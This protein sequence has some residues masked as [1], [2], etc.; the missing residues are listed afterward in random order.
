MRYAIF[1]WC[2]I[3]P[4][5]FTALIGQNLILNGGFEEHSPVKCLS[6]DIHFG[7]F[8]GLVYHW[9]NMDYGCFLCDKNYKRT[10][11]EI[12]WKRCPFESIEPQEG[13]AM[14]GMYYLPGT[15]REGHS[16]YIISKATKPLNVGNTYEA[17]IWICIPEKSQTDP[18]WSRNIGIAL[19]PEK[20]ATGSAHTMFNIPAFRVDTVINNLWYQIRW[21]IKPLCTANYLLIG[22]FRNKTWP[23]SRS[24]SD[25][26]YYVDNVSIIEIEEKPNPLI[27]TDSEY[28]CSQYDPVKNKDLIPEIE[29]IVLYF[30]NNAYDL[31]LKNQVILDSLAILAKKHPDLVFEVSGYADSIGTS[32]YLLSK[33]RVES[34][35][36]YLF[37]Y[38]NI[39]KFRFISNYFGSDRPASSNSTEKGR[40]MNRR[41]EIKQSGMDVSMSLYRKAIDNMNEKRYEEVFDLLR[42]WMIKTDDNN[43]ILLLFDP[44]FEA[45]KNDKKWISLDSK[46]RERYRV[47]KF[48]KYSF[49]LDSMRFEDQKYRGLSSYLYELSGNFGKND[50]LLFSNRGISELRLTERD[51][52]HLA[53][54]TSVL[55]KKGWPKSS[56]VGE[57]QAS[58]AFFIIQHSGDS[59]LYSKWLPYLE[60]RCLQGEASWMHYAMMY[61]RF[62]MIKEMPQRYGTNVIVKGNELSIELEGDEYATNAYRAKIGIPLLSEVEVK[63]INSSKKSKK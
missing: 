48:P 39:Q 51:K 45:L 57:R 4:L 21:R 11:D 46:I 33:M 16:S 63:I 27:S 7:K 20:V 31:E 29:E 41:V 42:K 62:N 34:T 1:T 23:S 58:T 25:A 26:Y 61:D 10:S 37:E 49:W 28:Y 50:S 19:L 9:D 55:D 3:F 5:F 36:N 54:L 8:P 22:V 13:N 59:M 35:I 6:C 14:I 24:F 40:V 38:N 2:F 17:S 30:E 12:S 56:E 18:N 44:R 43:K 32:N 15:G 52:V 47:F 60:S 53:N